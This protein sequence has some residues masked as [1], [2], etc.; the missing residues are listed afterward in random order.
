MCAV[1][2]VGQCRK[3]APFFSAA[4]QVAEAR[5]NPLI[6]S[7]G[8]ADKPRILHV[9]NRS[10]HFK[11]LFLG[12]ATLPAIRGRLGPRYRRDTAGWPPGGSRLHACLRPEAVP[13][14]PRN[15]PRAC[16]GTWRRGPRPRQARPGAYL[17]GNAPAD[18]TARPIGFENPMRVLR[19]DPPRLPTGK[20]VRQTGLS[21][22]LRPERLVW[23]S[24]SPPCAGRRRLILPVSEAGRCYSTS[25]AASS[26]ASS[27]AAQT[28]QSSSMTAAHSPYSTLQRSRCRLRSTASTSGTSLPSPPSSK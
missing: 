14:H 17:A 23:R 5:R 4:G 24:Q 20:G 19:P 18:P 28:V 3:P 13:V 11:N 2:R 26:S 6:R 16:T 15:G 7:F 9:E 22:R 1:P 25:S 8:D 10:L 27:T 12:A 21:R